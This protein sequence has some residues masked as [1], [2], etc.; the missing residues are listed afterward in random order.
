M[1]CKEALESSQDS[2]LQWVIFSHGE[3]QVHPLAH[4][5]TVTP[6][7]DKNH[8]RWDTESP[9]FTKYKQLSLGKNRTAKLFENYKHYLSQ[10]SKQHKRQQNLQ[11][12]QSDSF[13]YSSLLSLDE[14]GKSQQNVLESL[15]LFCSVLCI[16]GLGT[17]V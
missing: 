13:Y 6:L 17:N 12:K 11:L 4:Q 3:C 8:F 1:L 15:F 9:Y 16:T 14:S 7:T 2:G 5:T 10:H